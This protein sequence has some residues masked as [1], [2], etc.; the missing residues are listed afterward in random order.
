MMRP[1]T[2]EASH[3]FQ[4]LSNFWH[5]STPLF[6][7]K[8]ACAVDVTSSLP[9]MVVM[10]D[11]SRSCSTAESSLE[12]STFQQEENKVQIIISPHLLLD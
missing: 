1:I 2:G 11:S 6:A 8:K 4:V 10:S 12:E 7:C 5:T 3:L 9:T